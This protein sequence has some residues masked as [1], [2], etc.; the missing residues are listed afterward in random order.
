MT[1]EKKM[2]TYQVPQKVDTRVK[3]RKDELTN[4]LANDTKIRICPLKGYTKGIVTEVEGPMGLGYVS[5]SVGEQYVEGCSLLSDPI[6]YM[7]RSSL[8]GRKTPY[9]TQV[10]C[11]EDCPVYQRVRSLVQT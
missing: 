1:N 3:E 11:K 10:A 5:I 2:R 9:Q 4:I 7:D 6:C 8:R